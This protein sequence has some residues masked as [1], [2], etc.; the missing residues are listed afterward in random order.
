LNIKCVIGFERKKAKGLNRITKKEK[1][2]AKVNHASERITLIL[3][4]KIIT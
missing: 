1:K 2:M 3:I 4:L